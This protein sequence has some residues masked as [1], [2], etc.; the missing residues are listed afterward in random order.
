MWLIFACLSSLTAA[1]VAILAKLGLR[2]IDPTLAT[3]VRSVIM[4]AVLILAS[5]FLGRFHGF[6]LN[7]FNSRDWFLIVLAGIS[8]VLSWPF[9]FVALQ[10]GLATKV[11]VIDRL[12]LLFVIVFAA[13]FLGEALTWKVSIGALLMVAGAVLISA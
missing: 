9:Y 4:A 1:S 3:T 6:S 8:G 12:S 10:I 11:V 13:L 7:A 2:N 5:L